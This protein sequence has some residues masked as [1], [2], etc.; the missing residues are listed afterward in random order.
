MTEYLVLLPASEA[1]YAAATEQE[2]QE[3]HR[4]HTEFVELLER[5]GHKMTGGA[6]L[7]PSSQSRGAR[8]TAVDAVT[9]SDGP[10]AESAEQVGGYYVVETDDVD[11]LAQVCGRLMQTPFHTA[12]ELRPLVRM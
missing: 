7:T 3:L 8:G 2:K 12:V 5:R 10:Y 6:Q 1:R 11:D 4:A 9:L